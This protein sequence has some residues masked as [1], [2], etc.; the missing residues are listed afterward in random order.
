MVN[1]SITCELFT[2][3]LFALKM[4]FSWGPLISPID[5]SRV[6]FVRLF[7]PGGVLPLDGVIIPGQLK[8]TMAMA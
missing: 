5:A 6:R 7:F 4:A 2:I 1:N 3:V 8:P